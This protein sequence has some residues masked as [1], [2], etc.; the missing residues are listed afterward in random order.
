MAENEKSPEL[1]GEDVQ[2]STPKPSPSKSTGKSL[3]NVHF[4]LIR[5]CDSQIAKSFFYAQRYFRAIFTAKCQIN[6][7]VGLSALGSFCLTSGS[8]TFHRVV[9]FAQNRQ[10]HY[11]WCIL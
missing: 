9:V 3:N 7:Y 6:V 10:T 8:Y 1:S 2:K 5:F 4:N 11:G